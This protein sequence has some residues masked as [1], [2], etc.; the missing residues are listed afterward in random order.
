MLLLASF[1]VLLA[2]GPK[3]MVS[4]RERKVISTVRGSLSSS[5]SS[6]SSANQ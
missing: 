4:K 5:Q 1:I 6:N 3:R 2:I